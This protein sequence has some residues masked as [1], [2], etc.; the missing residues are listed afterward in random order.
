MRR[1]VNFSLVFVS[2][3]LLTGPESGMA[4]DININE[5]AVKVDEGGVFIGDGAI[6]VTPEGIT[7]P[8]VDIKTGAGTQ[9]GSQQKGGSATGQVFTGTDFSDTNFAG[10]DFS[11]SKFVGV[12][13]SDSNLSNAN[14]TGAVFQGVDFGDTNLTAAIFVNAQI[15]GDDFGR[16]NLTRANFS[17]AHLQGA[18][19]SKANLN[20]ACFIR[21]N[22]VGNDFTGSQLKGAVFTGANRIGNDFGG[23]DLSAVVWKGVSDCPHKQSGAARPQVT[24]AATITQ[25]L[26]QGKDA[27][28]DLTVNFEFDSD[29]IEAQGHAQVLEIAN[30]LKSDELA[31]QRVLIEGHTDNVGSDKYN[32]DLSYR[33]SITV[34]RTLTEQYGVDHGRVQVKGFGEAR[35]VADNDTEEGRAINRRVTLVN[36]GGS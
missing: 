35:P 15:Q 24:T 31:G 5:G 4:T 19:F 23:L 26:V 10:R 9:A 16:A 32:L 34:M 1:F 3:M 30:A 22:L 2:T 21:A 18:D 17:Q 6:K 20:G 27:R 11:G 14:F 33:R 8:G 13:F 25:A 12:D 36:L 28:V 7:V 29:R